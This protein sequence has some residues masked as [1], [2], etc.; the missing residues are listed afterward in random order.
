MLISLNNEPN[1]QEFEN[2]L[3]NTLS[4]LR[5][6]A[7]KKPK[8]YLDLLGSKLENEVYD[9]L[10]QNAKGSVF[11]G[12]IELI[13]G[14]KFPDIIAKKYYGIEVKTTKSNH[15]KSTGSSVAEGTRVDGIE[16]IFMLFGKMCNPIEFLCKPYE[17][18][19]SEVVVTHSPRYL[20][21]MNLKHGQTI[22][23]K[24]EI[25]YDELRNQPN[26]IKTILNYYRKQL[27]D[28]DDVWYLEQDVSKSTSLI[29]RVWNNLSI[30]ER[31][32]CMIKGFCL[33]PELVSSKPD[34]F[35]KFAIW[36]STREGII[37]P[38]VRDIYTSGGKENIKFNRKNFSNNPQ[39][40]FRLYNNISSIKNTLETISVEELKD[41]WK[42]DVNEKNRFETWTNLVSENAK[43][44]IKN[45]LPLTEIL[46]SFNS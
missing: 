32:N 40:I 46:E 14:Q 20:I 39:I 15:W 11:D 38:N 8:K 7:K 27:K 22:F 23:D 19:L 36:L 21:D 3:S 2:L 30:T 28:G 12:S 35:N 13:S 6:E 5:N 16:R 37:C 18:C 26:P 17:E 31:T 45:N 34:K 25:P 33:F 1:R 43:S 44:I 4:S 41:F 24:L 10:N 9:L 42:I 29:I